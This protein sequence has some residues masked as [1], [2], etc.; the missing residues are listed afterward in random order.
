MVKL[1]KRCVRKTLENASL[2]FKDLE[3]ALIETEGILNSRPLTFV[4]ENSTEP[5]IMPSCLVNGCRLL[6]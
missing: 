1:T 6:E 5:P 4:Y 3:M 2:H